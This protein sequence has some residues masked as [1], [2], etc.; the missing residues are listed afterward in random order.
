MNSE[1]IL[2]PHA[3]GPEKAILSIILQESE[4]LDQ[5]P[6]LTADHFYQ[7]GLRKL[8]EVVEARIRKGETIELVSLVQHLLDNGKL[9]ACGGASSVTDIYTYSPS[10]NDLQ[11]HMRTLTEKLAFRSAIKMTENV[12]KAAFDEDTSEL[13]QAT[14]APITALHDL[15]TENHSI[16]STRDSIRESLATYE[17]RVRGEESPMGIETSLHEFNR[18]FRGLHPKRTFIISGYPSGGKTLLSGQV[19][20]DAFME[21]HKTLFVSLEMP[22]DQLIDRLAAYIGRLPGRAITEP[23]EYAKD[24]FGKR[25]TKQMLESTQAAYR[26]IYES[27]FEIEDMAGANVYQIAACIRREHRKSPLQVV[28]VDFAQRI[29]P[30][31][32]KAK[33]TREQQLSH[34]S[35]V[36]ADLAKEL[37]FC[38]ILGSQL[39]KDGAAKHAEAINEDADLHLQI[40]QNSEKKHLGLA[41]VKDRHHGHGGKLLPI[42]M[43]EQ[44]LQFTSSYNTGKE[45]VR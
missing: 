43:H 9:E 21:G 37:S 17:R 26:K 41:V 4:K 31:S 15:L 16:R 5:L 32:E 42:V 45:V 29:R 34:A 39:N 1:P 14:S 27:P 20:A 22:A 33:E 18:L 40:V 19:A 24:T 13:L 23:I 8:F 28:V 38:L 25:P 3:V 36:L 7:P 44:L 10:R 35:G 11:N 12:R 6:S 30:V 2:Y